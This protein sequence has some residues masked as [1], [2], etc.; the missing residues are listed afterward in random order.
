MQ[1]INYHRGGGGGSASYPDNE[2]NNSLAV[3]LMQCSLMSP[4][5]PTI[6]SSVTHTSYKH[7]NVG[8]T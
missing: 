3:S 1:D 8:D 4:P 6:V 7:V 2:H 5:K